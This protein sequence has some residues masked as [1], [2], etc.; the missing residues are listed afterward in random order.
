MAGKGL[1]HDSVSID[2]RVAV[3]LRIYEH[4]LSKAPTSY[5]GREEKTKHSARWLLGVINDCSSG[6]NIYVSYH[7]SHKNLR[8]HPPNDFTAE[9]PQMCLAVT[10]PPCP[11][12]AAIPENTKALGEMVAL[13]ICMICSKGVLRF[14]GRLNLTQH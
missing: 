8:G 3:G 9:S 6:G 11:A 1:I 14:D 10:I 12:D 13:R 7:A 2:M 5:W 4:Y